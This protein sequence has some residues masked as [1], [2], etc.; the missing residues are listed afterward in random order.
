MEQCQIRIKGKEQ[1]QKMYPKYKRRI[2]KRRKNKVHK[3]EKSQKQN[4]ITLDSSSILLML[5]FFLKN[6]LLTPE[7]LKERCLKPDNPLRGVEFEICP[8]AD[9]NMA[10]TI[11][12]RK[13]QLGELRCELCGNPITRPVGSHPLSLT[14]EH[15]FPKSKGGATKGENL[16]AA[17]KICNHIK[18]NY[19]PD[20][21]EFIGFALLEKNGIKVNLDK[22]RY[23][24]LKYFRENK[25][26]ISMLQKVR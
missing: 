4:K 23:D 6:G 10:R 11:W 9:K 18:A 5:E 26:I 19:L 14:A 12:L 3:A 13:I 16:G 20:V 2:P 1:N 21:W 8:N 25:E 7:E 22:V 15:R 17:H 24:Y